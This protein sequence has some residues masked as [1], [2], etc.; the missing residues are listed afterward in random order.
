MKKNKIVLI[1]ILLLII[2]CVCYFVISSHNNL[3]VTNNT[4]NSNINKSIVNSSLD[5]N[6]SL[7]TSDNNSLEDDSSYDETSSNTYSSSSEY[8]DYK[9]DSD[10]STDEFTASD[11]RKVVKDYVG[12]VDDYDISD[13]KIGKPKYKNSKD[14][15][16]VPLYDKK[17]GKFVD[18][19][20][21]YD[22]GMASG[23]VHDYD[24][25]KK[26]ISGKKPKKSSSKFV[27]L[28]D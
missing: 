7:N 13:L 5:V 18:S 16:L 28:R 4:N 20:Y 23:G 26:I 10:G 14:G 22:D 15:W 2:S 11:A 27:N 8:S 12:V 21:A 25:Y 19:V 17:T 24:N 3:K 6:N 1:I 9:S